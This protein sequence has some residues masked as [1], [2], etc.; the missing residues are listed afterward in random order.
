MSVFI[1]YSH[2]DAEFVDRLSVRLVENNIKVWKDDMKIVAGDTFMSKIQAGIEGAS[3][4]CIV[5]SKNSLKS[6]WVKEEIN[7]ALIRESKERGIVILPILID[8]CEVPP[9]LSDRIFVDFRKDFASGLKQIL[10]VVGNKY[11]IGDSARIDIDSDYLFDYGIEQKFVDGR[12]FMQIDVVSFDKEETF[13]ILSQFKFY[14]NEH[15][16]PEHFDLKEGD[17]LRDFVLKACAQEFAANPAR[18]TVNTKDAERARFA[19]QDAEGV[20]RFDVEVRVKWLG[21]ASRETLLFN[22]GALFGQICAAC[23]IDLSKADPIAR[24]EDV[25]PE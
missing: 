8:D 24:E 3:Y 4:F 19:I 13:S 10:T 2:K 18:I 5:L 1:S 25:T 15:A 21:T 16:T 17:S 6:K 20:A 23:G 14:G 12:Y 22:V 11:N 7:E 9:L